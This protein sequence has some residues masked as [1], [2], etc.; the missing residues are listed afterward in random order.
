MPDIPQESLDRYRAL[1]RAL[2]RAYGRGTHATRRRF[3]LASAEL[4]VL[5]ALGAAEGGRLTIGALTTALGLDKGAVS[6]AVESLAARKLVS[7]SQ[8]KE[9]GRA[10]AAAILAKGRQALAKADHAA[11]AE[12]AELLA[13]LDAPRRR[14]LLDGMETLAELLTGDPPPS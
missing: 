3:G 2:A 14:A 5:A 6:R 8:D 12:A 9:D 7:R 13:A 10:Q 11:D 1:S 4:H